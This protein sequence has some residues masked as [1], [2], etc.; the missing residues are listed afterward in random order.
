MISTDF[1]DRGCIQPSKPQA[2][3]DTTKPTGGA[4]GRGHGDT[5]VSPL[6]EVWMLLKEASDTPPC[7]S[8]MWV[9][10]EPSCH[11]K[12]TQY[13]HTSTFNPPHDP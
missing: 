11:D 9:L 7:L 2:S 6:Q 5:A 10:V 4:A 12:V 8:E 3:M 13:N 1:R